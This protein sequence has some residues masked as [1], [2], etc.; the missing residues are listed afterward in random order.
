MTTSLR[1]N[2]SSCRHPAIINRRVHGLRTNWGLA[3]F[4]FAFA[5]GGGDAA[6]SATSKPSTAAATA[7]VQ[8]EESRMWMTVGERRFSI[9]LADTEAAHAFA[10]LMPISM[11]MGDLHG[12]EKY[13]DLPQALPTDASRPGT[14]HNGDL[15]LYGTKTLV[16]FYLT[17]DSA[18]SYTHL[19]RVDDTDGLIQAL[20]RDSVRIDFSMN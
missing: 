10:A 6:H 11:D 20:G 16:V 8:P 17:F 3:L 18:Y 1:A 2:Q 5:L 19:G 9:T 7:T 13:A 14:I 12:N 15:M 4:A